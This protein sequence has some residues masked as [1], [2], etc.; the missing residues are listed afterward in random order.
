MQLYFIRHGQSEN[1]AIWEQGEYINY[2]IADPLLTDKGKKQAHLLADFLA[3]DNYK[4]PEYWLDVQNRGSFA[5]THMYCSLMER[6]IQT[7]TIISDKLGI[8]L[9]GV[10]DMHEVGGIYL[11]EEVNGIRH[12][13]I[14]HGRNQEYLLKNYPNL[15]LIN[16][17]PQEGWWRGGKE[18]RIDRLARA[19]R[20]LEFLT[21]RHGGTEDR[22]AVIT[23]GGFF[24]SFFRV[25]FRLDLD[26][27][28]DNPL[29]YQIIY[30]NC[31]LTRFDLLG[32]QFLFMYHNRT[33][34]LPAELIT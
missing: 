16:E 26:D 27:P 1:N 5:L 8:P 19:Q 22:V 31:G 29:P 28:G 2:R 21:R 4:A 34:F 10:Q 17:I 20:V 12:V 25:L 13:Q 7:G 18:E 15:H 30:N 24:T 33:D 9:V 3:A 11:E 6:A 14:L 32:D 23:H